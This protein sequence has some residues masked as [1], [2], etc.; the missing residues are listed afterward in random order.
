MSEPSCVQD[1]LIL[2]AWDPN[3]V[4]QSLKPLM[5]ETQNVCL[6]GFCQ[7]GSNLAVKLLH[8]CSNCLWMLDYIED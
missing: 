1:G 3:L 4:S 8:V 6:V 5:L 2:T 7:G